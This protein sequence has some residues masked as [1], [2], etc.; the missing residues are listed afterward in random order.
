MNI[1]LRGCRWKRRVLPKTRE[2]SVHPPL[3]AGLHIHVLALLC[4]NHTENL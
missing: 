2:N 4:H 3:E 1:N